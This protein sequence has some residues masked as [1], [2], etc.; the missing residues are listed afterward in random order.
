MISTLLFGSA[1]L[2]LLALH[3]Y[4]CLFARQRLVRRPHHHFSYVFGETDPLPTWRRKGETT[5]QMIA[6]SR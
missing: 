5:S 3:Q 6:R 2:W 4:P 1:V